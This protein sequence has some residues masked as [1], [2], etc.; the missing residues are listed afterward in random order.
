MIF[1]RSVDVRSRR[2]PRPQI[3]RLR[4]SGIKEWPPTNG[5]AAV[6]SR[7]VS[8]I[9]TMHDARGAMDDEAH[10]VRRSSR[11]GPTV[12]RRQA[13]NAPAHL[14]SAEEAPAFDAVRLINLVLVPQ[15]R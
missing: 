4:A 10:R 8:E 9:N 13:A 12:G 1:T 6:Y 14:P 15:G 5:A 11:Q 2:S 3:C 7:L